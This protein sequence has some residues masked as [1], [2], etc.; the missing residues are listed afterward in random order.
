MTKDEH[1]RAFILDT[2][3]NDDNGFDKVQAGM[4]AQAMQLAVAIERG[5]MGWDPEY[6]CL[7]RTATGEKVTLH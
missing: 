3:S 1:I 5:I 7:F 4:V 2:I 6:L